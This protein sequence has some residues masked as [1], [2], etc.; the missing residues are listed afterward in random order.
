MVHVKTVADP[1]IYSPNG[2]AALG[3][4]SFV[5]SNDHSGKGNL[6]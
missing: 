6:S 5:T 4:G 2:I 1:A 3:G